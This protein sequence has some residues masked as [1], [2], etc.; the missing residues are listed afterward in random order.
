[1]GYNLEGSEIGAAFGLEQLKNF[2]NI[3]TRGKF[4]KT[5]KFF[6]HCNYFS[7]PKELPNSKTAWLAYPLLIRKM[8]HFQEET[9]KY[10]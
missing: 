7:I 2:Q 9:Y 6:K 5:T 3:Q 8:H 1:M 4:Y 10:I